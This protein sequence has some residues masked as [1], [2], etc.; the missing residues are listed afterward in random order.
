MNHYIETEL[1]CCSGQRSLPFKVAL[2]SF[3]CEMNIFSSTLQ[4][5][6]EDFEGTSHGNSLVLEEFPVLSVWSRLLHYPRMFA[7]CYRAETKLREGNV[8]TGVCHSVWGMGTQCDHYPRCIG[9]KVT[10]HT[11][12]PNHS[13]PRYQTLDLPPAPLLTAGGHLET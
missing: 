10:P 1:H 6:N 5:F 8:F 4:L 3:S 11:H 13:S 12:T 2:C 7:H 9:T